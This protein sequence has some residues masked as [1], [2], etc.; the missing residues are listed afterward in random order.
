MGDY[1]SGLSRN[2]NVF[3]FVGRLINIIRR[4]VAKSYEVCTKCCFLQRR[5]ELEGKTIY[6]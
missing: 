1:A 4:K 6:F 3:V 5:T 2:R